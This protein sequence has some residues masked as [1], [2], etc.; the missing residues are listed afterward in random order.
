MPNTGNTVGRMQH[1]QVSRKGA[2]RVH[3]PQTGNQVLV[4]RI[5]NARAGWNASS[6][7]TR[8][9]RGDSIAANYEGLIVLDEAVLN[10]NDVDMSEREGLW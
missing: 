7:T 8:A 6:L 10:V 9:C 5:D 4:A 1:E 3:V 2:M